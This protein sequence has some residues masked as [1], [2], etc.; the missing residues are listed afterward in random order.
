MRALLVSALLVVAVA[1]AYAGSCDCNQDLDDTLAALRRAPSYKQQIKGEAKVTFDQAIARLRQ[2]MNDDPWIAVH[3][4]TY[5]QR[6]MYEVADAHLGIGGLPEE[7]VDPSVG[8]NYPRYDGDLQALQAQPGEIYSAAEGAE[9]IAVIEGEGEWRGVVLQ[10]EEA[11]WQRGDIKFRMWESDHGAEMI[12]YARYREGYYLRATT[13]QPLFEWLRYRKADAPKQPFR[14]PGGPD[15]SSHRMLSSDVGYLYLASFKGSTEN[16]RSQKALYDSIGPQLATMRHLIID[17]RGNT[18]GGEVTYNN[19]L[20]WLDRIESV[21]QLHL[22]TNRRTASAA[23][24]FTLLM[25]DRGA[26]LYGEST[27]G[28][29]NYRYANRG[30][31]PSPRTCSGYR[32]VVTVAPNPKRFRDLSR[33]RVGVQPDVTLDPQR[34]WIEQVVESLP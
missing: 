4:R 2:E 18:G 10:S 34:D 14:A 9:Q 32:P 15:D 29:I 13:A 7:Q 25:Q 20:K 11:P 17:V 16:I 33:E 26:T 30:G 6:A 31:K 28:A 21:P 1:P 23:E 8:E 22:L 24:H 27:R 5:L 3:C 19:F 12:Y